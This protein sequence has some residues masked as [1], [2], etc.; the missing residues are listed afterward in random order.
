MTKVHDSDA[1]SHV[2]QLNAL[3]RGDEGT[4]AIFEDM[5]CEAANALCNVL[6]AE[7]RC[8]HVGGRSSC[9][10]KRS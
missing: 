2:Q 5:L 1:S 6:F 7:C 8:I 3:I 9:S 10:S 4:L